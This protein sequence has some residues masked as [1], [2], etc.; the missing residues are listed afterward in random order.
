MS[1]R[2][3][4]DNDL[5]FAI[6]KA[7]RLRAPSIDFR[8]AQG[9][10]LDRVEDPELLEM[11]AGDGRVLV[12]HDRRTM[13]RHFRDRLTAGKTSPGLLIVAQNA[14]IADVMEALLVLWAVADPEDMRDQ[15]FH[16]PSLMRHVFAP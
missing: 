15:A 6:V 7:V 5:R 2:F 4:A 16:I 9:S 14:P 1:I 3:Q 10:S 12:S 11:V 8:S 13:L